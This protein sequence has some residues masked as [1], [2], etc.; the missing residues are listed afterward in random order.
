VVFLKV[1]IGLQPGSGH[2]GFRARLR[3]VVRIA[4]SVPAG[5]LDISLILSVFLNPRPG[6]V[7]RYGAARAGPRTSLVHV[8]L[9][10][11]HF[12]SLL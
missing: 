10:L 4:G 2:D 8:P 1:H 3:G 7:H 6:S 5:I 9:S 11:H 12:E